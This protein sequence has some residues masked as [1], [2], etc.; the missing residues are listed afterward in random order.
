MRPRMEMNWENFI[1]FLDWLEINRNAPS[2][3]HSPGHFENIE[4]DVTTNQEDLEN[5][6][7]ENQ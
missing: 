4:I 6:L 3:I 7:E 1:G 2:Y 5:Y